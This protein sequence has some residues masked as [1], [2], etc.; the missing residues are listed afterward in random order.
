M[1][2]ETVLVLFDRYSRLYDGAVCLHKTII[3][4]TLTNQGRHSPVRVA[5]LS[6]VFLSG[7]VNILN[8]QYPV[9]PSL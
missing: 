1:E 7:F 6:S 2:Q 3:F 8:A 4:L 9:Q 5:A